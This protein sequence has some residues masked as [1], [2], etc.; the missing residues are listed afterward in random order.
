VQMSLR[1]LLDPLFSTQGVEAAYGCRLGCYGLGWW[2]V[3]MLVIWIA[4]PGQFG[5]GRPGLY[6]IAFA[7]LVAPIVE[8]LIFLPVMWIASH[9]AVEDRKAAGIAAVVAAALHL[10]Y[11]WRAIAALGLFYL[12]AASYLTWRR[13]S[14]RFAFWS[15][16]A[17]HTAFNLPA[18]ISMF[19]DWAGRQ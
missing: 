9:Y 1:R 5:D 17:V 2:I 19:L 8:N 13:V 6:E 7:L 4:Q 3:T 12:I 15:G 11:G 10:V 16:V 14:P 18:S